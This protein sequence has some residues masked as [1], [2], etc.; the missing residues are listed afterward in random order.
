[1]AW[2]NGEFQPQ[3]QRADEKKRMLLDAAQLLFGQSGYH[4]T[5]AKLIAEKAG[6]ATG[7]FYRYFKDK[8]AILMAVCLRM[9]D[10]ITEIIFRNA[11][12]MRK[13]GVSEKEILSVLLHD[14]VDA[15]KSNKSFHKEILA[16]QILDDDVKEWMEKREKAVYE[17][18][19]WLINAKSDLYMINDPE[20]CAELVFYWGGLFC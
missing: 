19:L 3:Q 4:K 1:V 13:E 15:H 7:T 12:R 16:L 11:M 18:V 5:T 2:I 20:A 9:E 17:I 10:N 14:A 8:K 6:V